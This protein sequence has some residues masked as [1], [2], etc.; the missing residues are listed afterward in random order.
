[1][2]IPQPYK[3]EMFAE[4]YPIVGMYDTDDSLIPFLNK[5]DSGVM[6]LPGEPILLEI[7]N[8]Y[9]VV[10]AQGPISGTGNQPI[11]AGQIGMGV[12][13]F[14]ADFQCDLSAPVEFGTPIWWNPSTMMAQLGGDVTDGFR[15]GFAT[16]AHP[17]ISGEIKLGPTGKVLCGDTNS[18]FIRVQSLDGYLG[19]GTLVS[20]TTS[21]S[22]STSTTTSG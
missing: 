7:N 2:P 15:I 17:R 13:R 12:K 11:D 19:K 20:T 9:Q 4:K 3:P 5:A 18:K 16:F 21:T 10:M 22:T 1:M 8:T 6:V 14:T